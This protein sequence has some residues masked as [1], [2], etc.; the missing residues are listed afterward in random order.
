MGMNMYDSIWHIFFVKCPHCL[1]KHK[2]SFDDCVTKY[3]VSA[4]EWR[5]RFYCPKCKYPFSFDDVKGKRKATIY[6]A[7]CYP[8]FCL[9]FFGSIGTIMLAGEIFGHIGAAVF[10]AIWAISVTV[11]I[12]I[13]GEEGQKQ[14]YKISKIFA[15]N[16]RQKFCCIPGIPDKDVIEKFTKDTNASD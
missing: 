16:A 2:V 8:F 1:T 10:I 3:K 5:P 14:L 13:L 12:L 6:N 7:L 15:T 9:A 11:F 4:N